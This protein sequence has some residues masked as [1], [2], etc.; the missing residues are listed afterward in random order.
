MVAQ[1]Q[2]AHVARE[3]M[4]FQPKLNQNLSISSM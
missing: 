4:N 3:K 1:M 2:K